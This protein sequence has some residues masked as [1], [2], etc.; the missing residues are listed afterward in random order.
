MNSDKL[1]AAVIAVG[2]TGAAS[3]AATE[4]PQLEG[5]GVSVPPTL[6]AQ[7]ANMVSAPDLGT[8]FAGQKTPGPTPTPQNSRTQE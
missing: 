7:L 8:N 6:I 4:A 1:K 2:L 5:Q 3:V